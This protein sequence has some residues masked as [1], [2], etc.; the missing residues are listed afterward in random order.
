MEDLIQKV[1]VNAMSD[2]DISK[3]VGIQKAGIH[4][5]LHRKEP[6]VNEFFR[7]IVIGLKLNDN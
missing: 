6:L 7:I 3:S 1:R 4:N 5:H 2:K